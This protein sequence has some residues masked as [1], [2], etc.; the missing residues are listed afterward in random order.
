MNRNYNK[1]PTGRRKRRKKNKS[2]AKRVLIVMAVIL[3]LAFCVL[4][5][6]VFF[7]IKTIETKGKS[8]YS[9]E[10]I[11]KAS[12]IKKGDNLWLA[13]NK[14]ATVTEK[15]PYIQDVKI[16]RKLPD[17]IILNVTQAAGEQCY[18]FEKQFYLCGKNM[19][20]LEILKEKPNDILTVSG[21]KINK[22][23]PGKQVTFAD[24]KAAGSF[25]NLLSSIKE[26][27]ID[28]KYIN[29]SDTVNIVFKIS[30]RFT[31]KFGSM[32]NYQK[33]VNHL[34][35]MIEKIDSDMTGT[36]DLSVWTPDNPKGIFSQ[37][38]R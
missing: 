7:P 14:A 33:K 24:T 13:G 30:N 37:S 19:K 6:T 8:T 21:L 25:D 28:V 10:Q 23:K 16:E 38:D 36:I 32:S 3:V 20:L 11:I 34:S 5:I 12:G 29:V 26:K 18:E 27:N 35:A 1:R 15:L 31:V 9:S 22:V 2:T 4:S 17:K